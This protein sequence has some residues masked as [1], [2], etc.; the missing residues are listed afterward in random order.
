MR[1]VGEVA[2]AGDRE[3]RA[4]LVRPD[5]RV[6]LRRARRDLARER[7]ARAD[8]SRRRS[9]R[10]RR[11]GR[12]VVGDRAA[13]RELGWSEHMHETMILCSWL[14]FVSTADDPRVDPALLD[15]GDAVVVEHDVLVLSSASASA[16]GGP[17]V[18]SWPNWAGS[19][20][21]RRLR[22]G[23]AAGARRRR[24]GPAARRAAGRPAARCGS[25]AASAAP[26]RRGSRTR[27]LARRRRPAPRRRAAPSRPPAGAP[28][29]RRPS[30]AASPARRPAC[31]RP[32]LPARPIACR[33][34]PP[35][36]PRATRPRRAPRGAGAAPA[37][38]VPLPPP[39]RRA[40]R[41]RRRAPAPA[42]R[43]RPPRSPPAPPA[44]APRARQRRQVHAAQHV[45]DRAGQVLE[46]RDD[47]LGELVDAHALDGGRHH[48]AGEARPRLA[49]VERVHRLAR[50]ERHLLG[51]LSSPASRQA[52]AGS[53]RKR[54]RN[55][56]IGE[57]A[58]DQLGGDVGSS[59]A[60]AQLPTPRAARSSSGCPTTTITGTKTATQSVPITDAHDPR[61]ARARS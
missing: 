24:G 55:A 40:R 20:A 43:H 34:A 6:E 16:S 32:R 31:R 42:P 22:L 46:V 26:S 14:S 35:A 9:T 2:R 17:P 60:T 36:R 21:R 52:A 15:V 4:D 58:L 39:C 45:A 30:G 27:R 23:H 10:C 38:A 51:E 33:A 61:R 49:D 54:S 47:V 48:H 8:R 28:P 53:R 12:S 11:R 50:A 37:A 18:P 3:R 25:R 41:R 19:T 29:R 57:Q 5:R 1:G 13:G 7:A 59:A 44:S 56:G